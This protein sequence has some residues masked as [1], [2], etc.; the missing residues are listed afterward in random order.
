MGLA[1]A[2]E[3]RMTT[4]TSLEVWTTYACVW[5]GVDVCVEP[6]RDFLPTFQG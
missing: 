5:L 1:M 2:P 6:E 3:S 4:E